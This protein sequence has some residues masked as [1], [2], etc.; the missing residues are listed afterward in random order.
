MRALGL[1]LVLLAGCDESDPATSERCVMARM[2]VTEARYW[3]SMTS[4]AERAALERR[5]QQEID[6]NWECFK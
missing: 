3:A 1:L 2:R 4:P 6:A 5:I